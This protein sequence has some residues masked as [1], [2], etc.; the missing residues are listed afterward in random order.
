MGGAEIHGPVTQARFLAA[1][2]AELRLAALSSRATP[3]QREALESGVRRLLDPDEMGERFKVITLASPD[4][5]T[6]AGFETNV[7]ETVDS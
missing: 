1:L 6:P 4:L 7:A 3:A 5:K 2:G